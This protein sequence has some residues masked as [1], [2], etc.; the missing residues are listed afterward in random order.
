MG[1]SSGPVWPSDQ[2]PLVILATVGVRP[3]DGC[4]NAA[5]TLVATEPRHVVHFYEGEDTLALA[6]ADF[7]GAG[8]AGGGSALVVATPA[9]SRAFSRVLT[10]AG[11]DVDRARESQLYIELDAADLLSRFLVD[12][13]PDPA[14]FEQAVRPLLGL[15]QSGLQPVRVYG[16]MVDLL[17]QAGDVEAA[18]DT[19]TLW[20]SLGAGRDFTLF[21]GYASSCVGGGTPERE[22]VANHHQAVLAAPPPATD[23]KLSRRFEPT[24]SAPAAARRFAFDV[25]RS[26]QCHRLIPEAELVVSELA[27][28][29]LVHTGARFTVDLTRL[30]ADRLRIEV[31]DGSSMLPALQTAVP[32]DATNGRGIRIVSAIAHE[33]GV[34]LQD[35]GKVVW[36]ELAVRS[37]HH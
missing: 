26:W 35:E 14:L 29:A 8:L 33:W 34:H 13:R 22:A 15:A 20:N 27:T 25:L 5:M 28:N 30:D 18:H 1:R 37:Q 2:S 31:S 4:Q 3:S 21:C 7:L 17:W 19:E 23:G 24:L 11:I 9:H 16:E 12:G 6:V 32:P 36:A 10:A